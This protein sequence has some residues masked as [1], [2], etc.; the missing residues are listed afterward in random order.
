MK[1][2]RFQISVAINTKSTSCSLGTP[3]A[4]SDTD[5]QTAQ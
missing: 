5:I 3:V 2:N 1:L 4:L